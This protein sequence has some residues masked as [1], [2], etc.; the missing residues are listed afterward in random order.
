[1][2]ASLFLRAALPPVISG[3]SYVSGSTTV[4]VTG[5]FRF[6]AVIPINKQASVGIGLD[7]NVA[8]AG[9]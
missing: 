4:K 3:R 9:S 8:T 7:E 1:M 6:N 5:A 2:R